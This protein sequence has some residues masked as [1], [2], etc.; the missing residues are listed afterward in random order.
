MDAFIPIF[1]IPPISTKTSIWHGGPGQCRDLKDPTLLYAW[2]KQSLINNEWLQGGWC[3]PSEI[4]R[5]NEAT[6]R[7]LQILEVSSTRRVQIWK[8]DLDFWWQQDRNPYQNK[9]CKGNGCS[10]RTRSY[11][12]CRPGHWLWLVLEQMF[13]WCAGLVYCNTNCSGWWFNC[14]NIIWNCVNDVLGT[15]SAWNV[16]GGSLNLWR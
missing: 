11:C 5:E 7:P 3:G 8:Q 6:G 15:Q 12:S 4:F 2:Q 1:W 13:R 16:F 10:G 14:W 9:Y